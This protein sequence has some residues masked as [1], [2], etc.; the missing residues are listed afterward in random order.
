M[1]NHGSPHPEERQHTEK[2]CMVINQKVICTLGEDALIKMGKHRD[3]HQLLKQQ[4]L[5]KK[6][7]RENIY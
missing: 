2:D 1:E 7:G 3:N 6:E 4:I 5:H